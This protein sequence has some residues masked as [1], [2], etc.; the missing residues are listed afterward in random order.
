MRAHKSVIYAWIICELMTLH[1]MEI[2]VH[3]ESLKKEEKKGTENKKSRKEML[4][5]TNHHTVLASYPCTYNL[6]CTESMGESGEFLNVKDDIGRE[7]LLH[8]GAISIKA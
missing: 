3:R 4:K 1:G 8:V 7:N 5:I 2:H 6:N